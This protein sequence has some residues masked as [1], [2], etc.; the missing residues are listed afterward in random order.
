MESGKLK[1]MIVLEQDVTTP[2][3]LR[4]MYNIEQTIALTFTLSGLLGVAQ[5]G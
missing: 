1:H 4:K 5:S 3:C 2:E